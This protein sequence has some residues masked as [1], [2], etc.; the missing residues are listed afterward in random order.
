[1]GE[2]V[3]GVAHEI[4]NP[5]QTIVGAVELM[6]ERRPDPEM[7]LDLEM[8]RREGTRAGQIVRNL[9]S[10]VRRSAPDRVAADLNEVIRAT[11]ELR[12]YHLQQHNITLVTELQSGAVP[13]FVNREEIQQIVLNLI[14]NAEQAILSAGRGSRITVRSYSSDRSSDPRGG[15]RRPRHRRGAARTN[16]RAVLHDEGGGGGNGPRP[17]DFPR[18][19][20]RARRLAG[21]LCGETGGVLPVD[22]AG[23]H[24]IRSIVRPAAAAARENAPARA[25]RGRRGAAPEAAGAPAQ[26]AGVRRVRGGDGDG[27]ARHRGRRPAV[28]RAVR[29]AHAGHARDGA[30][31]RADH[32]GSRAGGFVHL[33]HRRPVLGHGG[34]TR[35]SPCRCSSSRFPPKTSMPR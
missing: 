8:V 18:H 25:H 4:N 28:A 6:L 30:L 32:E 20:L 22:A 1:M 17:V 14:L 3:A 29:R 35:S 12:E 23:V 27:G 31:P 24:R 9:L 19:R 21:S 16:L 10:F 33:H 5:L 13:V 26:T 34:T 11:V 2:L 7:R 15:G